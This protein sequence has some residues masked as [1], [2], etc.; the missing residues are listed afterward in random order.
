VKIELGPRGG[1]RKEA[2]NEWTMSFL[3]RTSD[4]GPTGTDGKVQITDAAPSSFSRSA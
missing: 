4:L 3:Y 1:K 2:S